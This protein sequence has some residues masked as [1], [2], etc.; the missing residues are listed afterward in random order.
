M[1]NRP[2][3]EPARGHDRAM[4]A[5]QALM[6]IR[7]G[8]KIPQIASKLGRSPSLIRTV[9]EES[10]VLAPS[11]PF[12]LGI[13]QAD[14]IAALKSKRKDGMSLEQLE[15]ETGI[16]RRKIAYMLRSGG[17]IPPIGQPAQID[18]DRLVAQY[19][20]G[21]S[22]RELQEEFH[23]SYFRV[24]SILIAK[25]VDLRPRGN[26]RGLY[27]EISAGTPLGRQSTP[28]STRS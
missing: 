28:S 18:D 10:E 19:E 21:F 26:P 11:W 13:S 3:S 4:L 6:Q 12:L 27:R 15:G 22:L 5:A 25:G 24:R 2:E 23:L 16:N 1:N 7:K 8:K 20:D 14:K 9:L 17:V